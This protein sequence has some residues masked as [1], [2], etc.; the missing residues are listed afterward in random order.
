MRQIA[1]ELCH[2]FCRDVDGCTDILLDTMCKVTDRGI[3]C[4]CYHLKVTVV[5]LIGDLLAKTVISH[6]TE[7]GVCR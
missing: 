4:Q 3:V 7:A 1:D 6:L 5:R 2:G